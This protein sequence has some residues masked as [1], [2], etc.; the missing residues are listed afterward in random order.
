MDQRSGSGRSDED[1]PWNDAPPGSDA[2]PGYEEPDPA[3]VVG[4]EDAP[5]DISLRQRLDLGEADA[6]EGRLRAEVPDRISDNARAGMELAEEDGE[7]E[8]YTSGD[9][10]DDQPADLPAEEAAVNQQGSSKGDRAD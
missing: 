7:Q 1:M 4:D 8:I 10:E 6:L 2:F 3:E 5:R 9:G